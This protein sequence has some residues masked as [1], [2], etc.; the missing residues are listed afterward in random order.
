LTACIIS[1]QVLILTKCSEH[2]PATADLLI[3]LFPRYFDQDCFRY[4]TGGKDAAIALLEYPF[5]HILFTGSQSV[6]KEV[7]KSAAMTVSPVTL[8]LGGRNA[9]IVFE[10]ANIHLAAKR[11]AWAKFANA[12]QT[13]F[14]PN[15]AIVHESVFD[16]FVENLKKVRN[17]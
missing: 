13:C 14:A 5:G 9:V 10:K 11:I 15:V 12:G 4:I 1:F 17:N 7:I 3:E 8:E 6:G 16:N 2:S